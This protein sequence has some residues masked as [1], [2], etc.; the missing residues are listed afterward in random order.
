MTRSIST[1]IT[2]NNERKL[3][4]PTNKRAERIL[5]ID[6]G[7]DLS[8]KI[9]RHQGRVDSAHRPVVLVISEKSLTARHFAARSPVADLRRY[10]L[11]TPRTA[12][13]TVGNGV[14]SMYLDR[15]PWVIR[16]KYYKYE[17]RNKLLRNRLR[18][19]KYRLGIT[20][21][22]AIRYV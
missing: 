19:V 18:G 11:T 1:R 17:G 13:L 21:P 7:P 9:H 16:D 20:E 22:L 10:E 14:G 2:K 4:I 15:V 12:S 5:L 6:R 8:F 3:D